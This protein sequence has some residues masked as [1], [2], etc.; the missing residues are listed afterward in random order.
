VGGGSSGNKQAV[1]CGT[2][3]GNGGKSLKA[4]GGSSGNKQAVVRD[5]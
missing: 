1:G 2:W 4:G 3:E 5:T